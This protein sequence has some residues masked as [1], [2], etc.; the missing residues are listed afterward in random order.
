[1]SR[2][3]RRGHC[4]RGLTQSIQWALLAPVIM[5]TIVGLV[6]AAVWLQARQCAGQAAISGAEAEALFQAPAGSGR[7]VAEQ[8]AQQGGLENVHVRVHRTGGMAVVTVTAS[9]N[10]FLN[11]GQGRV[12]R[13]ASIPLERP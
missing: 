2:G 11:F 8:I 10:T 7:T 9:A 4:D 6:Q 3:L 5:L 12:S 1:M 13:T